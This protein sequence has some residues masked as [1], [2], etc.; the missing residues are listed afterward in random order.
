MTHIAVI[1]AGFAGLTAIRTLRKL[2]K[3]IDITLIS[4]KGRITLPA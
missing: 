4:P 2:D 3:T 1:G